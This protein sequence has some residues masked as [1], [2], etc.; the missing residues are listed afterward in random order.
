MKKIYEKYKHKLIKLPNG[1]T[2][3]VAGFKS[4]HLILSV[5]DINIIACFTLDWLGQEGDEFYIDPI[6]YED[7]DICLFVLAN[8]SDIIKYLNGK[9]TAKNTE[10]LH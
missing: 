1:T 5:D 6:Y 9:K 7:C 3:V 4:A 2:G 8:E 10:L